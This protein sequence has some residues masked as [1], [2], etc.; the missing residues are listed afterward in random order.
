MR[1]RRVWVILLAFLLMA[2]FPFVHKW[3]AGARR[4]GAADTHGKTTTAQ[5]AKGTAP[6]PQGAASA[7]L[8]ASV[9]TA[10][11]RVPRAYPVRVD[12]AEASA[13]HPLSFSP[14]EP[15]DAASVQSEAAILVDAT[16]GDVLFAK[17]ADEELPPASVTKLMTLDLAFDALEKGRVTPD[18]EFPVS[19][20]AWH[21]GGSSMFLDP[22][23][24]VRLRDLLYGIAVDSGNDATVVLAEGLAGSYDAFVADMNAHAK[25]LGMAHTHF[26]TPNGLPA[27]GH[28]SAASDLARLARHYLNAHP[29]ALLFHSTKEYTFND[30]TQYNQNPLLIHDYPGADGLKTGFASNCFNLVGTARRGDTRLIVVTLCARTESARYEDASR[31]LDWG[32]AQF[33]TVVPLTPSTE[34]GRVPV[35]DGRRTEVP[36]RAAKEVAVTVPRSAAGR[37]DVSVELAPAA[38]LKPPLSAGQV[39]GEVHVRLDGR[40]VAT[41]PTVAATGVEKASAWT[42]FGR[43]HP[44][45]RTGA[46]L[47]TAALAVAGVLAWDR[48]R[49]RRRLLRRFPALRYG[50][51]WGGG[52][53]WGGSR[54]DRGGAF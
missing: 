33:Q 53:S 37:P 34:L 49:R 25:E 16:T 4:S 23:M 24:K 47:A 30:I 19:V 45:L 9:D 20:R 8:S 36:V 29:E 28:Y 1:P 38:A 31:L 35:P 26:V 40:V 54:S 2:A 15:F 17:N 18:T 46:V 6:L 13:L 44:H 22:S 39:V 27:P 41:V 52:S 11:G 48:A 7:G 14:A 21:T 32:F 42:R 43:H 3:E 5:P 51:A 10:F 12:P 50:G